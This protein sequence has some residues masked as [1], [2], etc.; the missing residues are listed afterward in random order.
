MGGL[1]DQIRA[2]TVGANK[3]FKSKIL[4]VEGQDVE[5][6]QPNVK[7]RAAILKAAK[8][9]SGAEK[10]ELGE[11]QVEA[12]IRCCFEPGT[13]IPVFEAGDRDG[14]MAQPAGGW[15]DALAEAAVELLNVDKEDLRKN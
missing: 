15:F 10:L 8:A 7:A 6:R 1:R 9:S 4:N 13:D 12:I 11:L 14:L 3:R 2:A 5:V